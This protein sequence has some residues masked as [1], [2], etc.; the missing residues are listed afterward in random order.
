[1][2]IKD[3]NIPPSCSNITSQVTEVSEKIQ[4]SNKDEAKQAFIGLLK[5][6]V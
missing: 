6:K 1:M 2:L 3:L 5:E 4:Y